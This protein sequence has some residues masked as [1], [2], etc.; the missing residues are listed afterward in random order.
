MKK[1][2]LILFALLP[3]FCLAQKQN[4]GILVNG[5]FEGGGSGNGTIVGV[6][7]QNAHHL[8]E[9]L[10]IVTNATFT[11]DKKTYLNQ[12]G[13][14]IRLTS[15]ARYKVVNDFFIQG[16]L[17]VGGIAF[18]D[19]YAKYIARWIAGGGYDY[20]GKDFSLAA[21]YEFHSKRKLHAQKAQIADFKNRVIDGYTFGHK[22]NIQGA[23][24]LGKTKLLLLVNGEI[25][26]YGY[27]RNAAVYGAQLGAVV[28]RFWASGVSVGIGRAY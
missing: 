25:G 7:A 17:G 16:G 26:R 11:L 5:Q 15:L 4:V 2:L 12:F 1:Y 9:K 6:E 14:A 23:I 28:H 18:K 20:T 22:G 21:G 3:T 19:Q 10:K 24:V 13:G 27:Q 8:K